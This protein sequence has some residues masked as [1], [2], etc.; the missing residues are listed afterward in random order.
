[1]KVGIVCY[2]TI[3]GSGLVATELGANLAALGHEVHFISY[4]A[5]FKLKQYERNVFFHSV[6]PINYPLFNQ[7]LYTFAL[8]AKIMDVRIHFA[9]ISPGRFPETILRLSRLCMVLM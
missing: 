8:T 4:S 2:P 7:T 1:M 5:P 3:G 9:P 6:D